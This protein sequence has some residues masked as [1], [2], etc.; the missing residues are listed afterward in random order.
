MASLL[1][2]NPPKA[3]LAPIPETPKPAVMPDPDDQLEQLRRRRTAAQR[4]RGG[5][6]GTQ[7]SGGGTE[8]LG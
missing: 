5:R 4:A 7:L 1:M 2:P 8:T 6:S 3:Q